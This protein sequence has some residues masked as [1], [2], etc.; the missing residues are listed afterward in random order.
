M[1]RIIFCL[2]LG[3]LSFSGLFGSEVPRKT[4]DFNK[5]W[6]FHL[7]DIAE[8]KEPH[9]DDS[10]WRN[11][12]LPHDWSI[13]GEFSADHPAGAGGGAL[14]GGVGWYRKRFTLSPKERGKK[15]FIEFDGVYRNSEVWING[16]YLGKRP[17]GYI[18]FQYDLTP[19]LR[20]GREEN[21]IAV[22]VDNSQQPN[23]R[24]YS[25]SGIYR[26]VRLTLTSPV[27]IDYGGLFI[28]TPVVS[29][30]QAT[31]SQA[32][33]VRNILATE[34]DVLVKITLLNAEGRVVAEGSEKV[35]APAGETATVRISL[36]VGNPELWSDKRPYLYRSITRL[37]EGDRMADEVS[38][39]F[40]IRT[41]TFDI[42]KGF[43]L[44]GVP[45][46]IRGMCM[47]HDLGCLGAAINVRALERQLEILRGMGCNAVRT[48]HNPPAPELLDLCDRMGFLVMDEAFD[49]WRIKKTA[50]DYSLDFD[51]WHERDLRDFIR[52]DRNHP[53]VIMWSIGNEI[54]E[55]WHES[56]VELA[57]RLAEI[58]RSED[59]TRPITSACNDPVPGNYLI[60]S[61][62]LDIIGINYHHETFLDLPKIFPGQ[63]FIASETGSAIAT[64]GS[65]DMPSDSVRVWPRRWDQPE[66]YNPDYTCSSY[67]N[68]R[69]GWGSTHRDTW[70]L[71]KNHDFLSGM[72]YWTGFDYLGE[73][74]PYDWPAR[75][76]YFGIVDLAGF[77]KDAYYFYQA[78]WTD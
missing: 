28:T 53:C 13:E 74:T 59:P 62:A 51:A 30:N 43:L 56:G 75:S 32:T 44:N 20:Y 40:G 58:V 73:P 11:L 78:E 38:T 39:C 2:A 45:T 49:M 50:Y 9:Y 42:E 7:G 26:N 77:P 15:A 33:M 60:R 35:T 14:P 61:G 46:K 27:F 19:Y 10:G 24:W 37:Y 64:R 36:Q 29:E 48:S 66:T 3:I 1:A 12:D 68:C 63:K 71:I 41:I 72:F 5:N 31:V 25:G 4:L 65:Y 6:R 76:S 16:T 57:R 47:H 70:K 52:R 22:R 67:D 18:S 34:S 21:V 69:V 8:A 23:S 55:Q 54:M 17:Y